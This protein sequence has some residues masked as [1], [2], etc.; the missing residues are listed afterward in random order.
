[1]IPKLSGKEPWVIAG[2]AGETI[3][4]RKWGDKD[5]WWPI[6]FVELDCGLIKIDVC[7]KTEN[8]DLADCAELRIGLKQIVDNDDFYEMPSIAV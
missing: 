5:W 3:W 8:W 6:V 7:G 1:M 4:A 2:V